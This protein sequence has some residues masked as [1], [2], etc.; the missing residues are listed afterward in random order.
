MTPVAELTRGLHQV[1]WERDLA[2]VSPW[3][4]GAVLTARVLALA[5]RGWNRHEIFTRAG[6]LTYVTIFGLVPTIAVA[7]AMFKAFGGLDQAKEILLPR[8]LAYI[9]V[10]AHDD[11]RLRIEEFIDNIHGG[12]LGGAGTVFLLVSVASLLAEIEQA[13]NAIWEVARSRTLLQR[14]TIYWTVTTVTPT[15]LVAGLALPT[16]VRHLAPFEWVLG[17]TGGEAFTVSVALPLLFVWAGFMLL[18]R[19]VPNTWVDIRAALLGALVAGS[20]W[21]AAVWGYAIYASQAV[22]YS[23]IYGSLAAL[24]IFLL[25][26]YLTWIIV[27]LGAEISFAAQHVPTTAVVPQARPLSQE[28]RELL[29]LR[30]MVVVARRFVCGEPAPTAADLAQ[31]AETP[32][33]PTQHAVECL[34][35][36]G[37]IVATE[38]DARLLPTRDPE[39]VSPA[40]VLLALRRHGEAEIW[41]KKDET[42]HILERQLRAAEDAAHAAWGQATLADMALGRLPQTR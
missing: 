22:S 6:A 38:D 36:A 7:L 42:I 41:G 9:A 10:G 26:L 15:L 28:A 30:I 37:L 24:P 11:V 27:L 25:W 1:V 13:F 29:A 34:R 2:G 5:V 33:M 18:Y 12:A 4:R 35:T 14:L 23:S 16:A 8:V 21:I 40:D 39:H 3:R 19:F 17:W 31:E 20:L 32:P